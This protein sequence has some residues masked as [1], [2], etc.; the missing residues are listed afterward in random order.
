[1]S[2]RF[3]LI[4]R[5]GILVGFVFNLHIFT[6]LFAVDLFFLAISIKKGIK[7]SLFNMISRFLLFAA[8]YLL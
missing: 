7:F 1:M 2:N 5:N 4:I 3:S 8:S 6:S